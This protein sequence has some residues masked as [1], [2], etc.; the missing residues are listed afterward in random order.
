MLEFPMIRLIV[1]LGPSI[2]ESK[3][4]PD[5]CQRGAILV[6]VALGAL[7]T[8]GPA[9]A[10]EPGYRFVDGEVAAYETTVKTEYPGEIKTQVGYLVL[11]PDATASDGSTRLRYKW[12]IKVIRTQTSA[13]TF[14][15][16]FAGLG[17]IFET[18]PVNAPRITIDR[19]GA[20]L[21]NE[22]ELNGAQ[23]EGSQGSAWKLILQPLPP[24]GQ[25]EWEMKAPI[26]LY[27]PQTGPGGFVIG[28]AKP[29]SE[30]PGETVATY[31]ATPPQGDLLS[32]KRK[33]VLRAADH[34]GGELID[35]MRGDG[36]YAFD[37]KAGRIKTL[38]WAL[39]H[40]MKT[41]K[42]NVVPVP[43]SV[44]A[45]L[46]SADEVMKV[47]TAL[48][49]Q[50]A[51]MKQEEADR[52]KTQGDADAMFDGGQKVD[53]MGNLLPG[54]Q[55]TDILGK[56][57][58][59]SE[60]ADV[61]GDRKPVLGFRVATGEWFGKIAL[62]ELR[63]I[64]QRP[65][66]KPKPERDAVDVIARDGYAVGSITVNADKDGVHALCITF[67]KITDSGLDP[68][69]A[70][71]SPWMGKKVGTAQKKLTGEGAYIYGVCGRRG[72]NIDAVGLVTEGAPADDSDK[73]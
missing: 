42:G 37:L 33:Y 59:G 52:K 55:P 24:Q 62:R 64:Y 4:L 69:Q 57:R 43:I 63:P 19:L 10:D 49:A 31:T 21:D 48:A 3:R 12:G 6:G 23:L 27:T 65:K 16:G 45:R 39:V 54:M 26:T 15:S 36:A 13:Q 1:R 40:D 56:E 51:Q 20:V 58:G 28:N 70:Y 46:M 25:S 47:K 2:S 41:E 7:V 60:F 18:P 29:K 71:V 5:W 9:R 61:S 72:L 53:R 66:Q 44:D 14:N 22:G 38:R 34:P 68:K 73:P 67:M 50:T 11:Y 17:T 35:R 30:V 8:G 32:V